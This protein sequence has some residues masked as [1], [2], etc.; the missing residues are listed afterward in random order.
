M[1]AT[2]LYRVALAMRQSR[3]EDWLGMVVMVALFVCALAVFEAAA[4]TLLDWMGGRP[5]SVLPALMA[6][7]ERAS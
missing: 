2:N 7:F 1:R 4:I 3:G 5:N 6:L